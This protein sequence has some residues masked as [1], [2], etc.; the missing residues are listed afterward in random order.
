MSM[1]KNWLIR[2]IQKIF[3]IKIMKMDIVL[4]NKKKMKLKQ[5]MIKKTSKN[6]IRKTNYFKAKIKI[7]IRVK[8]KNLSMSNLISSKMTIKIVFK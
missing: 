6:K 5:Y 1:K 3:K 4:S 7:I 2:V 8:M